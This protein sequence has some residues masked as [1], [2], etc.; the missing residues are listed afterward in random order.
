MAETKS[1]SPITTH[2][3]DTQN[4][5]AASGI[6]VELLRLDPEAWT[7]LAKSETNQDGRVEGLLAPGSAVQPGVYCL[8]FFTAE[9]FK[10]LNLQS[11]YPVVLVQF[12]VKDSGHYHIPLLL[13]AFGYSTYKG[14]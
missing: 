10:K 11:L 1:R 5:R 9:Y 13:S 8:K 4:G 14:T 7:S 12:E 2:I 6:A 3:L